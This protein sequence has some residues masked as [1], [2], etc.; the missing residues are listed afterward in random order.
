VA[1]VLL[2][3]VI[4]DASPRGA[5]WVEGYP[6]NQAKGSDAGYFR[7]PRSM[8]EARGFQPIEVRQDYTVMRLRIGQETLR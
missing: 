5:L 2:D 6:H 4:A 3:R 7:G 8:Y 1:S